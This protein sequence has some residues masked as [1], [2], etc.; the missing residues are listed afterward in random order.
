MT[1]GIY[2]HDWTLCT[3]RDLWEFYTWFYL[4]G[5][6]IYKKLRF[7]DDIIDIYNS[8]IYTF[9][10]GLNADYI[11]LIHHKSYRSIL[12]KNDQNS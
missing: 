2:Q 11:N 10:T 4:H 3:F 1:I 5:M 6:R 12:E 9:H 7:N 8:I